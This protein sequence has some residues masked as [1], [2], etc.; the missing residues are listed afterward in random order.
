MDALSKYY[1][2]FVRFKKIHIIFIVFVCISI[3]YSV[4]HTVY[5]HMDTPP[6]HFP[7]EKNIPIP[8]G[9]LENDALHILKEAGVIRSS[10]LLHT[11]LSMYTENGGYIQAGIYS[12]PYAFTSHEIARALINGTFAH[13][14]M[15]L[16][17]P[18]GFSVKDFD[19]Y[20]PDTYVKYTKQDLTAFEGKLFPDTYYISNTMSMDE[21][22]E[23]LSETMHKKLAPY[24]EEIISSGFTEDEVLIF[25][26]I[27]ER[28]ARSVES[29]HHVSGILH[30]RLALEMPLQVDATLDYILN[31]T[32][33]ELTLDDLSFDSPFNTYIN[34]GLPPAPIANPGIQSIEAVLRPQKTDDIYYLTDSDGVFHYAKTFEEHV[35]NKHTYLR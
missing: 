18:E 16:M 22:I 32:S 35:R 13:A 28:E 23:M 4:M 25:A 5:V 31:K 21:I 2:Y 17:L 30:N 14:E 1:T 26:S 24:Q 15:K 10:L 9:T 34:K 20:I 8:K 12:F 6:S 7:I 33:E 3:V 19:Q 27:L 29:M 11:Q